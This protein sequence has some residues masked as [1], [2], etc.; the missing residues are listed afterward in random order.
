MSRPVP[1]P[2]VADEPTGPYQRSGATESSVARIEVA[3]A[4]DGGLGSITDVRALLHKRLRFL[5]TLLFGAMAAVLTIIA[6]TLLLTNQG[7]ITEDSGAEF[8]VTLL[9]LALPV[10]LPEFSGGIPRCRFAVFE[11][12]N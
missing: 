11:C 1:V 10:C 8:L 6:V 5:A 3:R 9:I 2:F 12:S 7:K 4:R